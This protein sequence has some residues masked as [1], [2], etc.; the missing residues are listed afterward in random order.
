MKQKNEEQLRKQTA[1]ARKIKEG[2][3][4]LKHKRVLNKISENIGK[5]DKKT[6]VRQA[7]IDEGY[8]ESYA[9]SGQF[10]KTKTWSELVEYFF[11][12]EELAKTH[13][14]LLNKMN[15]E[16]C[17]FPKDENDKSII[18][19]ISGF[20]F[21]VVKIVRGNMCKRAYFSIMDGNVAA[22]ALD[23]A[24]KLKKKYGAD[25][26]IKN[27]LEN[28]TYEELEDRLEKA[29]IDLI[30]HDRSKIIARIT[31]NVLEENNAFEA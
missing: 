16:H 14:E 30:S 24:Y 27:E 13:R 7:L 8:S 11:P 3:V 9:D 5:S 29:I 26:T 28:L 23:M 17:E 18:E 15:V 22:K 31:K 20:G 19:A 6:S 2:A 4:R 25:I 21:R 1:S 12:D 10:Q